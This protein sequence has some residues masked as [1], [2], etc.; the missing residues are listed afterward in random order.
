MLFYFMDSNLWN[1][2]QIYQQPGYE[3]KQG[4]SSS[5]NNPAIVFTFDEE[6]KNNPINL[7]TITI[8]R[9]PVLPGYHGAI[10]SVAGGGWGCQGVMNK[11]MAVHWCH[12]PLPHSPPESEGCVHLPGLVFWEGI[13]IL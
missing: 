12:H 8:H 10:L 9:F 13:E 1:V 5:R 7:R 6:V 3:P 11:Q 2:Q 4:P